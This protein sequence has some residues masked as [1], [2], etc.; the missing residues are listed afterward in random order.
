MNNKWIPTIRKVAF[1]SIK[2]S[3]ALNDICSKM[4][5]SLSEIY[6]GNWHCVGFKKNTESFLRTRYLY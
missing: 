1:D 6:G 3:N 5:N 4:K 2:S